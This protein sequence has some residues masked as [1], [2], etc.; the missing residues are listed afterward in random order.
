MS[1]LLMGAAAF[2]LWFFLNPWIEK[3]KTLSRQA[4]KELQEAEDAIR[5]SAVLLV[6]DSV[7]IRKVVELIFM[8][9]SV[10]LTFASDGKFAMD[11]LRKEMFD[12]V[13]ADVHMPMANG[14]DVC[15]YAKRL[16]PEI[17]RL[18]LV[19]AFESFSKERYR[20]CGAD[21]VLKKPFDSTDLI[22]RIGTL[23]KEH[24]EASHAR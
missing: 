22:R 5:D 2:V 1:Y 10:R 17:F 15:E 9:T 6:D 7:T 13:I 23:L 19:G 14:Y 20:S 4:A 16:H 12:V 21:E 18:L 3:R 11:L 8:E 24:K